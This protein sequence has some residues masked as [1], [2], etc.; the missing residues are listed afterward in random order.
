MDATGRKAWNSQGV[1]RTETFNYAYPD[2]QRWK[3]KSDS[4]YQNSV[5]Q[6]VQVLYGGISNQ[7]M[8]DQG[9]NLMAAPP[10]KV[11]V[12][13]APDATEVKAGSSEHKATAA[14]SNMMDSA[15]SMIHNVLHPHEKQKPI[16][17]ETSRGGEDFES[18]IGKRT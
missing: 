10:T 1:R 13:P 16:S 4:D 9:F 17:E 5:Q 11:A 8:S 14:G 7:F 15:K 18:E 12:I 2:T 6:A 3:Y